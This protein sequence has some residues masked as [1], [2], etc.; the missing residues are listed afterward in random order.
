MDLVRS[1]RDRNAQLSARIEEVRKR[2]RFVG[3][4]DPTFAGGITHDSQYDRIVEPG[5]LVDRS[6][7][8]QGKDREQIAA[9]APTAPVKE[10]TR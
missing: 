10:P 3:H 8:M 5:R 1:G 9:T 6:R 7:T 2:S 4:K